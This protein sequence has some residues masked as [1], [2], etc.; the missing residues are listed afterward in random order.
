MGKL[1]LRLKMLFGR[2]R[3]GERLRD[4]V[5]FHVAEQTRENLRAGMGPEEAAPPT[6]QPGRLIRCDNWHFLDIAV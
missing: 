6:R 2:G 4:E 1:A 5:E 3:E